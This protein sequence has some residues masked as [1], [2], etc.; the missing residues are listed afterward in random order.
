MLKM[1]NLEKIGVAKF[2][3]N[4]T[5]VKMVGCDKVEFLVKDEMFKKARPFKNGF[6]LVLRK[7]GFWNYVSEDGKILSDI[8]FLEAEEFLDTEIAIVTMKN[9]YG[10]I[11]YNC[12]NKNGYFLFGDTPIIKIEVFENTI[13]TKYDN[14]FINI[15][16]IDGTLLFSI[17]R[18]EAKYYYEKEIGGVY[19]VTWPDGGY[20][21]PK[22]DR[23]FL[24]SENFLDIGKFNKFGIAIVKCQNGLR[25]IVSKE[26]KILSS[27]YFLKIGEFS[28]FGLAVVSHTNGKFN[29]L[30]VDGTLLLENDVE[31]ASDFEKNGVAFVMP[32]SGGT[33]CINT[34][35]KYL[36]LK[37]VE[38]ERKSDT[39]DKFGIMRVKSDNGLMNYANI[40]GEILSN[41]DFKMADPFSDFGIAIV[42]RANNLYNYLKLDGS[43]LSDI[44]FVDA[45]RFG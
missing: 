36:H 3:K 37:G 45:N 27:E 31:S 18:N 15:W 4:R 30:K 44:D 5:Y 17:G 28:R 41:E 32:K 19:K 26:G 8:D 43:F 14:N 38:R 34:T 40:N 11:S 20:N 21:Y 2:G 29:Y 12:I 25:N 16:N 9:S 6:G 33:Y 1:K 24:F 13:M 42:K 10:V 22:F 7:N 35:G 23:S 39:S